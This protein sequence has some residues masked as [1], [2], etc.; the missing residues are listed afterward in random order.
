MKSAKKVLDTL[1]QDMVAYDHTRT[2]LSEKE[3]DLRCIHADLVKETAEIGRL[4]EIRLDI[5]AVLKRH[6]NDREQLQVQDT[7]GNNNESNKTSSTPTV[8]EVTAAEIEAQ[9]R[10]DELDHDLHVTEDVVHELTSEMDAVT[11]EVS[12]LKCR[13]KSQS[14]NLPS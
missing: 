10:L 8:I 13:A 7:T 11:D 12:E 1:V 9:K 6:K 3:A 14:S 5:K 2:L 4:K